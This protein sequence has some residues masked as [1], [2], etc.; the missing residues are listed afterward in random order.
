VLS[1][2]ACSACT[3]VVDI[4]RAHSAFVGLFPTFRR[5]LLQVSFAIPAAARLAAL[6]RAPPPAQNSRDRL[7]GRSLRE[8]STVSFES[9][10][11]VWLRVLHSLCGTGSP[12]RVCAR[13][14]ISGARTH[15]HTLTLTPRDHLP[16]CK[17]A[18]KRENTRVLREKRKKRAFSI[19][20]GFRLQLHET[21][22]PLSRRVLP[23]C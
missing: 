12:S 7:P 21:L 1:R 22:S 3:H 10:D 18:N 2:I 11:E 5:A 15:I 9:S 13:P 8:P 17:R 6:L 16:P 14:L 20:A 4:F 23:V 19:L